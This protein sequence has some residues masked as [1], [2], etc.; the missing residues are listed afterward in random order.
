VTVSSE[1]YN[2]KPTQKGS[3]R[4]SFFRRRMIEDMELHSLSANTQD[5]YIKGVRKLSRHYKRSPEKISENQV[6]DFIISLIRK[7]GLAPEPLPR[8]GKFLMS[9]GCPSQSVCRWCCHL[10]K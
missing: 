1:N 3:P 9:S 7:S 10:K 8:S 2:K 5:R 6:R 4:V